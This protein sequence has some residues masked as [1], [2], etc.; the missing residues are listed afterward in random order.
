MP[1]RSL[2]LLLSHQRTLLLQG[3]MGPF[4]ERL[5]GVLRAQGQAVWKV[6]FNGG[7]DQDFNGP[8]VI[9]FQAPL[10]AWP[11]R[12]RELLAEL[13]I[14]ALVLFGQS[15]HLHAQAIEAAEEAGISVYVFEEGYIRPDYVT[16]ERGGVN[17]QSSL[18]TE[19]EFYRQLDL[20]PTPAP[21]PTGQSFATM[22][23]CAARYGWAM[24]KARAQYPHYSHHR[25]LSPVPEGLLWLRGDWRKWKYRFLE[26]G[27]WAAL[28][29]PERHKRF[30]L[31]PLQVQN[32]SQIVHHSRYE[33]MLPFID[34]VMESFAARAD[35]GD[36]LVFKHHPMDRPY[37]DFTRQIAVAAA[38]FGLSDRVRYV[39]D[40][41]LPTLLKAAKGVVTVNS[42]TGL[43]SL[44]HGTPVATL[45]DAFYNVPGMVQVGNL[46]H[47]WTHAGEVDADLFQRYRAFVIRETQLNASFYADAP[48]L[49]SSTV[50]KRREAVVAST[51]SEAAQASA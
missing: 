2:H 19:A 34:D 38:K 27:T 5:A 46:D 13:N 41:H 4:F 20:E 36:W 39:H 43:Q 3:P 47:F 37:N 18:P 32:D 33:S 44:F 24:H 8:G 21:L 35:H 11:H 16:L 51:P 9:R 49:S 10:A 1:P 23:R 14:D 30:F 50:I 45:G 17:A 15:R 12:I 22:A 48:G 25:S 42:T 6:N 31:V 7:D 28:T 40:L 29:A 26:R